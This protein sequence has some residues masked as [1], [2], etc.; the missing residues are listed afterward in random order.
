VAF[1]QLQPLGD[2]TVR[3]TADTGTWSSDTLSE[4]YEEQP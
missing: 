3:W 2:L 1:E 4:E